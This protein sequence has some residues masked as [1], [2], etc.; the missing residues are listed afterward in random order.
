LNY[1]LSR[2]GVSSAVTVL[3]IIP[4]NSKITSSPTQQRHASYDSINRQTINKIL[5]PLKKTMPNQLKILNALEGRAASGI[6]L[7]VTV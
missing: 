4:T 7:S 1:R 5:N 2:A 3:P 6:W